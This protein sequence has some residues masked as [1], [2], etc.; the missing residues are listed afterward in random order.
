MVCYYHPEKPAVGICKHCQRS[1]CIDCAAI[2]NDMLACKNR[3]E[4]PVRGLALVA[5]RNILQAKSVG[6]LYIRNAIFYCL[7]G[8]LFA[9]FGILQYRFLGWQ[10]V[11]IMS[12]GVFLLYAAIANFVERMKYK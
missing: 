3:H 6:S 11:F 12:I 8:L 5:E 4:E 2:V 9:G 1:L 10:A 7:V